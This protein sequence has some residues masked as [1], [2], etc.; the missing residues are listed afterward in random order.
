VSPA[1]S[2]ESPVLAKRRMQAEVI[3]PIFEEMA[4]EIGRERAEAILGRAIAKAAVA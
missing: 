1:G 3:G 4:A 2:E